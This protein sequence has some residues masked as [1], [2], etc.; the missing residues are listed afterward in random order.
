ME[1]T[2]CSARVRGE[3]PVGRARLWGGVRRQEGQA[4]PLCAPQDCWEDMEND[5]EMERE[6]D[7]DRDLSAQEEPPALVKSSE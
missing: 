7:K 6:G 3:G 2:G 1:G 5:R 4:S